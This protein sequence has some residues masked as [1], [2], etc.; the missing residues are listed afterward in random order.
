MQ[1]FLAGS[2]GQSVERLRDWLDGGLE[3][4]EHGRL[5]LALGAVSS[6]P[7][8][9]EGEAREALLDDAKQLTDRLTA[10][11]KS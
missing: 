5:K 2:Y 6:V 1:A 10:E 7:N 4:G 8:L 11:K 9:V 3:E